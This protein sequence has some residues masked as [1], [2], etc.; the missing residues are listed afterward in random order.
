M[1]KLRAPEK[2]F[3]QHVLVL[4]NITEGANA[5][6][7]LERR[8]SQRFRAGS[9][10]LDSEPRISAATWRQ[11]RHH[12]LCATAAPGTFS[13]LVCFEGLVLAFLT[14]RLHLE[15]DVA[16]IGYFRNAIM[17]LSGGAVDVYQVYKVP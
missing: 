3:T 9:S 10:L 13:V 14:A 2:P 15:A 8:S 11:M 6:R 12:S 17:A 4:Q 7:M 16:A 1:M 5:L